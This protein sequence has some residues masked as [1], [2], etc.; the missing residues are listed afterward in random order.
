MLNE[1]LTLGAGLVAFLAVA[2]WGGNTVS[3]KIATAGM[4]P[5]A[6]A[7][8][9]FSLGGLAVGAF[10][11]WTRLPLRL[12]PGETAALSKLSLLFIVQILLLNIGTSRT[13]SAHATV[14]ISS[15]PFATALFAHLLIPGDRLSPGKILGMAISFAGVAVIFGEALI[16][17]SAGS[18]IGDLTVFASCVL[19]R[20]SAGGNQTSDSGDRT[21]P[22]RLLA[23]RLER[24]DLLSGKLPL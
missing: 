18:L 15:Y 8:I 3:I 11:R 6:I 7:A 14:L 1:R 21:S 23:V 17:G 4:P 12:L 10:A 16:V 9:R 13:L 24:A 5:A 22:S 2:L 19:V 20:A